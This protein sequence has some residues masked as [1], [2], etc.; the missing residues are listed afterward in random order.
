MANVRNTFTE[1]YSHMSQKERINLD[2]TTTRESQ[3][4]TITKLKTDITD[5]MILRTAENFQLLG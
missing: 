4:I 3:D 5:L 1:L 2:K